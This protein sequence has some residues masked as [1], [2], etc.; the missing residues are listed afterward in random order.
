MMYGN[1][2]WGMNFVWWFM[3]IMLLVWI[4]AT[5][6]RI[7]GQRH[8]PGTP[9]DVLRMR[10]ASGQITPEQYQEHMQLLD[11]GELRRG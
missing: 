7:P 11:T 5:P 10:L 1:Y 6:F 3:W 4:F 8:R 9:L 2:F